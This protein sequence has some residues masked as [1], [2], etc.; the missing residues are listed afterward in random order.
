VAI[1]HQEAFGTGTTKN[2]GWAERTRKILSE[3]S[4]YAR[5]GSSDIT[6]KKLRKNSLRESD[7]TK[8]RLLVK[9]VHL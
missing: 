8:R 6:G 4:E 3:A 2:S 9:K 5:L 1:I 7:E